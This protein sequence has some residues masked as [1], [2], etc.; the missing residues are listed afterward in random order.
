[1]ESRTSFGILRCVPKGRFIS[2]LA[3]LLLVSSGALAC[4]PTDPQAKRS[5]GCPLAYLSRGD[6]DQGLLK[7][8]WAA[9]EA[10]I[11]EFEVRFGRAEEDELS[12]IDDEIIRRLTPLAEAGS[13]AAK[14][15]LSM[16]LMW[17]SKLTT[18]A[19][20]ASRL[21]RRSAQMQLEAAMA[22]SDSAMLIA[23]AIFRGEPGQPSSS[24]SWLD[25]V[26]PQEV[27]LCWDSVVVTEP[28]KTM[29]GSAAVSWQAAQARSRAKPC[30]DTTLGALR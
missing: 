25:Q 10:T 23:L 29:R 22:G 21:K 3:G 24:G 14:A 16:F 12:A 19:E 8:E 13:P 15:T 2:I 4:S 17:R 7:P 5:L 26:L 6:I 18:D 9:V 28:P 20:E 1:M 27:A 30:I 11:E